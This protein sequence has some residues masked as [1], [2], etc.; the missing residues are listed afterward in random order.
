MK[1]LSRILPIVLLLYA[2]PLSNVKAQDMSGAD[3]ICIKD[4]YE[5]YGVVFPAGFIPEIQSAENI[6]LRRFTPTIK[7]IKLGEEILFSQY[8]AVHSNDVRFA[9]FKPLE[10]VKQYFYKWN[11]QYVGYVD[12]VGNLILEIQMLNFS[13]KRKANR[14]FE[15][16]QEKLLYGDGGFYAGNLRRFKLNL[17]GKKLIIP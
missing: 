16:W 10:D 4:Y 13:N 8:N 9:S 7:Q 17:T 12:E 3:V 2:F 1:N 14:E 5:G 6:K 15:G 11:R